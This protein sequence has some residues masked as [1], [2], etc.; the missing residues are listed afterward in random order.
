MSRDRPGWATA[1]GLAAFL[2]PFL[3]YLWT[4]APSLTWAHDGADGG[5]FIAAA[6]TRGV[7]HPPGY[8]TYLILLRAALYLPLGDPAHRANLLSALCAAGATLL[9]Y[10]TTWRLLPEHRLKTAAALSASLAWAFSRTLWGQAVITEAYA[11]ASL[12]LASVVYLL[13]RARADGER[14]AFM[15]AAFVAGL[16]MGVHLTLALALPFFLVMV[17]R[18]RTRWISGCAAFAA[19][20]L[21]FLLL[22]M[23]ASGNPPIDWGHPVDAKGFFWLVSGGPY[24]R[25]VLAVPVGEIPARIGSWARWMWENLGWWGLLPAGAGAWGIASERPGF[26]RASLA[27]AALYSAYAITYNT[28]DSYVYL[29][30]VG[31]LLAPWTAR[32]LLEAADWAD[33]RM[34]AVALVSLLLALPLVPLAQNR[35]YADLHRNRDADAYAR[36]VLAEAPT[37]SLVLV[38]GDGETFALWYA[39]Y[40]LGLRPDVAVV[41]RDLWLQ[42]SW[43]R[44]SLKHQHPGF[45]WEDPAGRPV[46]VVRLVSLNIG[47]H[48]VCLTYRNVA[49]TQQREVLRKKLLWVM[50]GPRDEGHR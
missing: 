34:P 6:L 25:L 28:A 15:A 27:S 10:L 13:V 2:L 50:T 11:P 39:R 16:G 18:S 31:M 36:E 5:D 43:Y 17:P 35:S 24:R 8:P 22:P 42:F 45:T 37:G 12:F 9:L 48:P 21:T 23:L 40:G 14:S 46:S 41:N 38:S 47:D 32:G 1:A 29:I 19:G 44:A 26:F 4:L 3:V 33:Q 20:L 30:P 7:P 49:L